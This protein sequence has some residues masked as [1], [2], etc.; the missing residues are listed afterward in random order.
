MNNST[1]SELP[2]NICKDSFFSSFLLRRI[3]V[4]AIL[5]FVTVFGRTQSLTWTDNFIQGQTPTFAQCNNWSQFLSGLST[6]HNYVAVRMYGSRDPIGITITSPS[7]A[8]HLAHL[9]RTKTN[10]S[11]TSDGHT[12][13]VG[14]GCQQSAA[15]EPFGEGVVLTID[16]AHNCVC[17]THYTIRPHINNLN[18]GG[19]NSN[20]C[21]A[22]SQMMALEFRLSGAGITSSAPVA[23]CL[24]QQGT[25]SFSTTV[26][27][28]A[29]NVFT[30]QLSD[31]TGSFS[32]PVNIGSIASTTS[33]F[34]PVNIP[35][36]LSTGAGYRV[37]VISSQPQVI[38]T[39]NGADIT[40][41]ARPSATLTGDVT[42]CYGGTANLSVDLEGTPPWSIKYSDGTTTYKIE[43]IL[44]SP[45]MLAVSP[46]KN[47]TYKLI[48]VAD[49]NCS[50]D[51]AGSAT[52]TVNPTPTA[53]VSQPLMICQAQEADVVITLTTGSAAG[54]AFKYTDGTTTKSVTDISG[55][56]YTLHVSPNV[57]TTYSLTDIKDGNGC[58]TSFT[59][60][61]LKEP[62]EKVLT[63]GEVVDAELA[64]SQE[65]IQLAEAKEV[66]KKFPGPS[67]TVT[68][69]MAPALTVSDITISD[70][71]PE[72]CGASLEFANFNVSATGTP[73]ILFEY[74]TTEGLLESPAFYPVGRTVVTAT[75]T[76]SCGVDS[77]EFIVAVEDHTAPTAI[78]R[79]ITVELDE[80]GIANIT[81]T[82]VDGGSFDH[83]GGLTLAANAAFG[84]SD[85]NQQRYVELVVTDESGNSSPATSTVTVINP[86]PVLESIV[87]PIIPQSVGTTISI[88]ASFH[89]KNVVA[90][91]INW[92][93]GYES[94]GVLTPIEGQ[95]DKFAL[96]GSHTYSFPGVYTLNVQVIDICGQVATQEFQYIVIY[97]PSA[98][99]VTGGGWFNSPA[100]AHV[101]NTAATGKASF[102][103]VSKYKKGSTIPE[104]NTDFQFHAADLRFKST[105]YEWLVIAGHKAMYKGVGDLNGSPGYGFLISA[106]D[107]DKIST[108][109]P[110]KFRIKIWDAAEAIV[111]DNQMNDEDAEEATMMLGGGSIVIHDG[112]SSLASSTTS[113][114]SASVRTEVATTAHPNPFTNAF[115]IEYQS[116]L[117]EA[118][119]MQL[120]DVTGRP[121]YDRLHPFNPLG[122]YSVYLNE[123]TTGSGLYILKINQGR[124]VEFLRLIRK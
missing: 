17:D 23:F 66:I 31:A 102:G 108:A 25:V 78:A 74:S 50:S 88:S 55:S 40:I 18:W 30:A 76:N 81:G 16:Q 27:F 107:G 122:T 84:C 120:L 124:R 47:T 83:C 56:S 13:Y 21:S 99:F 34:I 73:E 91:K 112:K 65:E 4:S 89:D 117:Q 67:V 59:T 123:E 119:K 114:T 106:V 93:D 118:L 85:V 51:G 72:E 116:G 20:S 22:P 41:N 19:I 105:A 101:N 53:S 29:G 9:L 52:V 62:V 86:L 80:E 11:V 79:N 104:G 45:F 35:A 33:G 96:K 8:A 2:Q 38:G 37:R 42:I 36:N 111:Y 100:G 77:K 1:G 115:T 43:N 6:T 87:A 92:G 15:C 54:W 28:D 113:E 109:S 94:A 57:T 32:S 103:F 98:G 24:D 95:S 75:A 10:G 68:V 110:D 97:D 14:K 48:G 71:L 61:Q 49:A 64:K 26:F 63:E 46:G 82:D 58:V 60:E 69:N 5:V 121:V 39:D 70:N 44:S 7:A 3:A 90:N 12:W